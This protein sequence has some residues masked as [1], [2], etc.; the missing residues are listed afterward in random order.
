MNKDGWKY[1]KKRLV[2]HESCAIIINQKKVVCVCRKFI[3]LSRKWDEDFLNRHVNSKGCKQKL[4]QKLIYCFFNTTNENEEN[5]SFEEKYDSDICENMDNDDIITINNDI[6]SV[7]NNEDNDN[8]LSDILSSE[9]EDSSN[10]RQ[11][12]RINCSGLRSQK[13]RYYIERTPVQVGDTIHVPKIDFG[14][15][16]P[17][18]KELPCLFVDLFT[19]YKQKGLMECGTKEAQVWRYANNQKAVTKNNF[20]ESLS[21]SNKSIYSIKTCNS[22]K[23]MRHSIDNSQLKLSHI[24]N[25]Q[26]ISS[27]TSESYFI[28]NTQDAETQTTENYL[29]NTNNLLN[30]IKKLN[31]SLTESKTCILDLN[32]LIEQLEQNIRNQQFELAELS[33]RLD[34][35]NNYIIDIQH[36]YQEQCNE[37]KILNHRW[38]T[39]Y[40][41]QQ[42]R[43]NAIVEI[44]LIE[45]ENIYND[46]ES[47]IE[48][49]SRFLLDNLID[50]TP[51]YWLDKRNQVI[52]KFIEI[53]TYNDQ[54]KNDSINEKISNV[55]LLKYVSEINLLASAIKYSLVR[56]KTIINIDN[57][58]T[59][60][61]CYTRFLKWLKELSKEQEPLPKGLLFLAFDNEQRGQKNYLDR[62]FNTVTFH[63]VTSFVT[64]D[65]DSQ[66]KMQQIND[67]WLYNSLTKLQ[68]EGLFD[69]SSQMQ[70][71]FNHELYNYLTKII[72]QLCDEKLSTTNNIDALIE[73]TL[74]N[75][76]HKKYCSNCNEKNIENRKQ[77]CP[78]C[79]SQLSTVTELRK[80]Q[81]TIEEINQLN[82][83]TKPLSFKIHNFKNKI[84]SISVPQISITQRSITDEGVC[85]PE[86]YIPDPLNVNPNSIL[87][88]EKVLQ[89]I[90]EITEVKNGIRKWVAITCD[91]E[92]NMLKAYV[93]LNWLIDIKQFAIRQGYRTENQLNFFKKCGD[94]HK[95]W[96]SIWVCVPEIYI[97]DPLNVNP[98]SILNVEKVLQHIEEITEVKNGIRKWVAI[99]CD[100]EMNMLKAYVELNWLIDI[101]QFAIRQGYRTENQLNFFKKCGDHHK[102]WDSICNIYRHAMSLELLWPYVRNYSNPSVE[103]YLLWVKEQ[104]NPIYQ[105][106]YEQ[107]FYYLQAIIN[108]RTAIRTNRLLL[109]NAAR[110]AFSPIW[111][112]RCYRR[113]LPWSKYTKTHDHNN[114]QPCF[115]NQ[116]QGLDAILEEVNKALK[117]L[118]PPVPQQHHWKIV[119]R[120][121]KKF[122]QLR[123]NF[124]KLIGS[125]DIQTNSPR[126]RP[127]STVECQRFQTHLRKLDFL[128]PVTSKLSLRSLD[129]EFELSSQLNNFSS[130]AKKN[131]QEFIIEVFYKKNPVSSPHSSLYLPPKSQIILT[132]WLPKY[133]KIIWDPRVQKF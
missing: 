59:S 3:K 76:S 65:I 114:E 12:K 96:D 32:I 22:K 110:R 133:A 119:A 23:R 111:S 132:L 38:D 128:N 79:Q 98:N 13:I 48:N 121:C 73:N 89:H 35:A 40:S 99:T 85:V 107:I 16:R 6:I 43:I 11:K 58:I 72:E 131:R 129:G 53:L 82:K 56:S 49:T 28:S 125:N 50:Y 33:S 69:F 78:K 74:F 123:Q 83:S 10:K 77:N 87:N 47:L 124:F 54:N 95:A 25:T 115:S 127:E 1:S 91:G 60:A 122:F 52:V 39:R 70:Q 17:Y 7:D 5:I 26:D 29:I 126:I 21:N 66:N 14:F 81:K 80:N 116:Y 103:G 113:E 36:Q 45:R 86:I 9:D 100:G 117:S 55:Q 67:P 24:S 18:L 108:Y 68:Y 101:K 105:I 34:N 120:N 93:E 118:I 41:N 102:A 71:E 94:H 88:V 63:T 42:K 27:Q 4:G 104:N 20:Y 37:I 46:I 15:L 84:K 90:E 31:N 112:A 130:I 8:N 92:M 61:G 75:N 106:K 109:K 57:Y 30:Q 51:Q 64:F 62:R 44:A 19:S 2:K 97:P